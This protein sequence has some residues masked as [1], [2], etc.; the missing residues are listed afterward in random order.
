[1]SWLNWVKSAPKLVDN[2]FDKDKG[3]LSQVGQWVGHQQFTPEEQAMHDKAMGDAVRGFAVAT[4]GENTERSKTRRGMAVK[5]F[6]MQIWLIKLQVLFFAVDKLVLAV[7]GDSLEL[8]SGF[9]QITFSQLIW[10]VTSGIGLF[11]WGSHTMR[12]SKWAKD[13][14]AA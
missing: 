8:S 10:A 12:G 13:S 6:D 1:M 11:F 3:L 7:G 5:W 9:A 14:K 2:V 4:M